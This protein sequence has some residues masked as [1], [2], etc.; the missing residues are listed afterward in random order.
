MDNKIRCKW[1]DGSQ[2]YQDYHDNEWGK[3]VHNDNKLFEI[4]TT[5]STQ[6]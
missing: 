4:L 2:I 1:L 3:P 6:T 5:T